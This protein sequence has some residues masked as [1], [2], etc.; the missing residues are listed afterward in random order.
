VPAPIQLCSLGH[1]L[2][3]LI[4]L[5]SAITNQN[6]TYQLVYDRLYHSRKYELELSIIHGD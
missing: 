4:A 1:A 3:F 6:M 2:P 5:K